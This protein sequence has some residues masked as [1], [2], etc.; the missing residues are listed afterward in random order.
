MA[1]KTAID[2]TYDGDGGGDTREITFNESHEDIDVRIEGDTD[3]D[4]F[5]TNAGTDKVGIGTN[6]PS[7]KLEVDG[8]ITSTHITASGNI[9]ASGIINASR[10]DVANQRVIAQ[11][12]SFGSDSINI[13]PS[14]SP[15]LSLGASKGIVLGSN[16]TGS[17]RIFSGSSL[18]G[19]ATN[20]HRPITTLSTNPFTA[21]NAT[22]GAYYRAGGNIT[23]SIFIS[24]SVYCTTGVEF[25]FIQTSSVGNVLFE[26]GS[27]VTLNSKSG[28]LKLAGQFSAAT[29]KYVGNNEWDLIG[30]LS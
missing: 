25:E 6:A 8:D 23:C 12:T 14:S 28:N 9:S 29:L 22:A 16:V 11:D 21:S 10:Y 24:A 26:T 3:V 17:N 15:V 20:I 19:E 27:G 30:D 4:L 18:I 5:F 2:L 1:G 7:S 13:F